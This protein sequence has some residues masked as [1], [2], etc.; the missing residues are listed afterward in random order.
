MRGDRVLFIAGSTPT[1]CYQAQFNVLIPKTYTLRLDL[2]LLAIF[3]L[4][5]EGLNPALNENVLVCDFCR[6][7][8]SRLF[9]ISEAVVLGCDCSGQKMY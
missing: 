3:F 6:G 2:I 9:N 4:L 8:S 5:Q 1:I 7:L